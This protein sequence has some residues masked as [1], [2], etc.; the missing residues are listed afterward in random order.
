[1]SR[2]A[3]APPSKL[4]SGGQ[5]FEAS[6]YC[7]KRKTPALSRAQG[8]RL[9]YGVAVTYFRVPCTLSSAQTRFTVLF[10]IGRRG[11]TL[12]WTPHREEE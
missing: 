7:R 6:D 3:C 4:A 5:R 1:M 11:S 2:C 8:F 9:V 10:G 12:P